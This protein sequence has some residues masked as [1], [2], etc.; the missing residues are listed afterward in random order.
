LGL[1]IPPSIIMIVYGV[2]TEVSIAHLFIAGVFPGLMLAG[3]FSG[4]IMIWSLLHPD[5]IPPREARTSL[6][7]KLRAASGLIP[8]VLLILVVLGS[9][10]T[11]FATATEAAAVGVIGSRLL[12]AAQGSLS[13]AS[14]KASV[15]GATKLYCMMALIL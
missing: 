3:L 8:V 4:Y 2:M 12:A 13:W 15:M 10:Y 5:Q 11:G 9:I 7:Q 6:L 1:L 14:F